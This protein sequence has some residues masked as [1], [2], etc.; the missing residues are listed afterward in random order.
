MK[1]TPKYGRE[2]S[3]KNS[4]DI[5]DCSQCESFVSR[6]FWF[7]HIKTFQPNSCKKIVPLPVD[8]L[9]LAQ[10]ITITEEFRNNILVKLRLD[11]VGKMCRT[12]RT[13]LNIGSVFYHKDKVQ[14]ISK[15]TF[16]DL[17]FVFFF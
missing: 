13:I 3:S 7:W 1:E 11:A 8:L 6:R 10:G 9:K 17:L 14:I 2:R 16:I 5:A 4:K 12:D 15:Y